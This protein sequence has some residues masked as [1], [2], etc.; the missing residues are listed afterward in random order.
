MRAWIFLVVALLL[1]ASANVLLKVGSRTETALAEDAS[2]LAKALA[3]LNAATVVGIALFAANV[4]V[5]RKALDKLD[6]SLAYPIMVAGG[7]VVVAVAA[8]LL[9]ILSERV[10]ALR[11]VGMA[12]IAAGVWMVAKS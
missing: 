12:V 6:V 4:L 7:M 11:M 2:I 5:Y 1:N 3:F 10:S 8:A 9:P